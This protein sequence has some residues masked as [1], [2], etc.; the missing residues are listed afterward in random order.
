MKLV[1]GVPS[2]YIRHY[3]KKGGQY[4][5]LSGQNAESSPLAHGRG[6]ET[7]CGRAG[8]LEWGARLIKKGRYGE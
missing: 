4:N 8:V 3:D 6:L 1:A 7:V 2:V 5:P